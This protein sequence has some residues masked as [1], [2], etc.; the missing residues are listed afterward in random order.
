MQACLLLRSRPGHYT[1]HN[2]SDM[3]AGYLSF[4][5]SQVRKCCPVFHVTRRGC[6]EFAPGGTGAR[7]GKTNKTY[8]NRVSRR[9]HKCRKLGQHVSTSLPEGGVPCVLHRARL[10]SFIWRSGT[11]RCLE[12]KAAGRPAGLTR[13][14]TPIVSDSVEH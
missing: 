11:L 4:V 8:L 3:V 5:V 13:K 1:V 9:R 12:I 2:T 7:I 14:S 10:A 6:R